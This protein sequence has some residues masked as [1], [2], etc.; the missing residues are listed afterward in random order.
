M[1]HY[2]L[3]SFQVQH[4]SL[5]LS[6]PKCLPWT[7]GRVYLLPLLKL[8]FMHLRRNTVIEPCFQWTHTHTTTYI[9]TLAHHS[10]A[11]LAEQFLWKT[12]TVRRAPTW[13]LSASTQTVWS[14]QNV[15]SRIEDQ[16]VGS[17]P[18][19]FPVTEHISLRWQHL[20][21]YTYTTYFIIN[22]NWSAHSASSSTTGHQPSAIPRNVY[23]NFHSLI[24]HSFNF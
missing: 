8:H 13:K 1:L 6:F 23:I 2:F 15:A 11:R 9:S 18:K 12:I 24:S 14:D 22:H 3:E 17:L 5:L 21:C 19:S 16:A 20:N 4:I 10:F 7:L